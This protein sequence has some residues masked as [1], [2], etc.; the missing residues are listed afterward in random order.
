VWNAETI[1][2]L[3]TAAGTLVLAVATFRAT[4]SA[5]QSSRIAEQS[6]RTAMRPVLMPAQIGDPVQKV[7]FGDDHWVR[8]EG[9]GAAAEH[10]EKTGVIYLAIALR[11]VGS[12]IGVLQGWHPS[13]TRVMDEP[14]PPVD[15]FRRQSRDL[16]VPPG[17]IGFWQGAFRDPEDELL[18]DF[19]KAVIAKQTVTV[20][21]LYTDLYGGQQTITRFAVIPFPSHSDDDEVKW[22]GSASRHWVLDGHGPR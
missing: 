21:L 11:N 20:H 5:N 4:A 6:L 12:G 13:P 16:Y 19:A 22:M 8:L 3:T 15:E 9:P 10:D 14:H 7:G 18:E 17:G 1:A 2:S